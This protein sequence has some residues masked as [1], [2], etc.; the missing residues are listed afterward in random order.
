MASR[1]NVSMTAESEKTPLDN[2]DRKF[3]TART[4]QFHAGFLSEADQGK[5]SNIERFGC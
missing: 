2:T 3:E 4:R 1:D 5:I